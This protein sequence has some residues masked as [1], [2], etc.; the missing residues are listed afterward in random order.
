MHAGSFSSGGATTLSCTNIPPPRADDSDVQCLSFAFGLSLRGVPAEGS[1]AVPSKEESS[2]ELV[3]VYPPF[4]SSVNPDQDLVVRATFSE[5]LL[6]L[7]SP[8]LFSWTP[9]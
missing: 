7:E 5:G 6:P 4:S 2:P 3:R 9:L 8:R 1:G